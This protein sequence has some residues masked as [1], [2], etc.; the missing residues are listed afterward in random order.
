MADEQL[1]K[2]QVNTNLFHTAMDCIGKIWFEA[3][4]FDLFK[5]H[6][7]NVLDLVREYTRVKDMTF[8]GLGSFAET[9][10]QCVIEAALEGMF[11]DSDSAD[12]AFSA[13]GVG[14]YDNV[15]PETGSYVVRLDEKPDHWM[16]LGGFVE[17]GG[18]NNLRRVYFA[19][20]NGKPRSR[21]QM[22]YSTR[23]GDL[24]LH[25]IN[26]GLYFKERG[27]FN[28]DMEFEQAMTVEIVP[29]AVHILPQEI[30]ASSTPSTYV[31]AG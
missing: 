15:F 31:T 18:D 19:D 14:T 26:P 25:Y 21:M 8:V 16:Y 29:L 17:V 30:A 4:E 13:T 5:G 10:N 2:G 23:M 12:W 27:T 7:N 28:I 9:R 1:V 11:K 6:R 24:A 3:S 20:V 22:Q